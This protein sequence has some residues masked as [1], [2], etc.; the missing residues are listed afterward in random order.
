MNKVAFE[1]ALANRGIHTTT[2]LSNAVGISRQTLTPIRAGVKEPTQE[3]AQHIAKA[4]K[5]TDKEFYDIFP[6][7]WLIYRIKDGRQP[8]VAEVVFG[9]NLIDAGEKEKERRMWE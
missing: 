8:T 7:Q 2:A 6:A 9:K 1:I 3:T 5:F 4:L